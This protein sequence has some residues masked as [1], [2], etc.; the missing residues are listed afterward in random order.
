LG[1]LRNHNARVE[2]GR[3]FQRLPDGSYRDEPRTL[4]RISD[5]DKILAMYPWMDLVDRRIFLAGWDAGERYSQSILSN[6][7]HTHVESA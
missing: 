1:H 4:A 6:E 7:S 3:P 2:Y 5:T